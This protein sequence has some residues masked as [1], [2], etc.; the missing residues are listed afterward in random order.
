MYV[1][2]SDVMMIEDKYVGEDDHMMMIGDD[3]SDEYI[4]IFFNIN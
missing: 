3:K 4:Y 1:W 2:L